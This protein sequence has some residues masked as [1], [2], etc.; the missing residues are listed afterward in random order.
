M[1]WRRRLGRWR[2][3][4]TTTS[5]SSTTRHCCHNPRLL[6]KG[7]AYWMAASPAHPPFSGTAETSIAPRY[8][9]TTNRHPGGWNSNSR[10]FEPIVEDCSW[11]DDPGHWMEHDYIH[12]R[13]SSQRQ[14]SAS[15]CREQ[16]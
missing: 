7:W 10:A 12:P 9:H 11:N 5:N 1:D 4:E 15:I 8:R 3:A 2:V 13:R 6:R 16:L 14:K